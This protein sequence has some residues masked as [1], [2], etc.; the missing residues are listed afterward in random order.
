M[1]SNISVVFQAFTEKFEQ[2]TANA[3]KSVKDFGKKVIKIG[4]GLLAAKAALSKFN[5]SLDRLNKI[6]IASKELQVSVNFLKGMS[7]AAQ[8]TG[9]NFDKAKDVVRE[10]NIRLGELAATGKGPAAEGLRQVGLTFEEIEKLSPEDRLIKVASA[11]RQVKDA[12][13]KI[14]ATGE[15]FGGA[16]EDVLDAI[17]RLPEAIKESKR[18]GGILKPEDINRIRLASEA[19]SK[20]KH[21]WDGLID[22]IT[23]SLAPILEMIANKMT[24]LIVKVREF[25]DEWRNAQ[26]RIED[27]FSD[28]LFGGKGKGLKIGAD[29]LGGPGG[30][31]GGVPKATGIDLFDFVRGVVQKGVKDFKPIEAPTPFAKSFSDAAAAQS[32]KAFDLLNPN[33]PDSVQQKQLQVQKAIEDN[34]AKAAENAEEKVIFNKVNF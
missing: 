31:G 14:F 20:L 7:F 11:L 16:G 6:A 26:I 30:P 15:L 17:E 9:A 28:L 29:V 34:T 32:S 1:S 19:S 27:I 3:G 24:G 4:A 12:G 18:I 22:R 33:R 21:A 8:R 10:F 23:V 5:E 13:I 25:A 2:K